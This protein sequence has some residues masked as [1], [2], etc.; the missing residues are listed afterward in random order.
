MANRGPGGGDLMKQIQAMQA[1]LAE[2]QARLE[3]MVFEATSGGGAVAVK[4]NARPALL[5]IVVKPEV[6]DPDDVDM[7]Q[8]LIMA[9]MNDALEK[10]RSGQMQQLAGL[11]G[12]LNIPGLN[13]GGLT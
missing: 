6:I 10:V 11:A 5:E 13:L 12:G 4:M 2:A 3:E 1:K 8:D 9:A 7:L